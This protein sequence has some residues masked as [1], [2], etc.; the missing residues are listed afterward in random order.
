MAIQKIV[1]DMR[2]TTVLDAAKVTTGTMDAA[3]IGSGTL[4][5]ARISPG[6]V[7]QHSPPPDLTAVHQAIA[8]LGLHTAVSDNKAAFNLPN[9]FID[10]FE[11]DTGIATETTVD[12]NASEYVSSIVGSG[13]FTAFPYSTSSETYTV[14]GG[15]SYD[16]F[17]STGNRYHFLYTPTV[18]GSATKEWGYW[19]NPS[20]DYSASVTIDYLTSYRWATIDISKFPTHGS[21]LNFRIKYSTDNV[22]Y[23]TLNMTGASAS[24]LANLSNTNGITGFDSTGVMTFASQSGGSSSTAFESIGSKISGFPPVTARY[25]RLEIGTWEGANTGVGLQVFQP[26]SEP[27]TTSATGT[28]VSDA[29]TA[30]AATTTLSG[31]ILYTDEFG[32]NTL[33]SGAS[34][35]LAI[36]LTANLQGSSPSWIGTNWTDVGD[37]VGDGGGYGTPQTFSGTTKQ[38]KLGKTTVTSG[39]QVAMKAVWA[40]QV[41]STTVAQLN[42]WAVNY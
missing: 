36:Y 8:T 24:T 33:G 38:V 20:Q 18:G 31:V 41:A 15:S 37:T 1:D 25:L 34:D 4:A 10:T 21:I 14:V 16:G 23:T 11:D 5:N 12:R 30:P 28:L 39:T 40:N 35:N 29:Q 2:T 32:T 13:V 3:R 19:V 17:L 42:G 7:T 6:S 22:T 26:Y 27:Q 9:A